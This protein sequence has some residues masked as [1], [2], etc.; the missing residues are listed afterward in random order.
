[1]VFIQK[2]DKKSRLV[3]STGISYYCLKGDT[4]SL[5]ILMN[6]ECVFIH[7][8]GMLMLQQLGIE[9]VKIDLP[10][11]LDHVNC[12]LAEGEKGYIVIDTG[13][14]DK[15]ARAVWKEMLENKFVER[16]VLTHLHPDHSGYAGVLQLQTNASVFMTESDAKALEII[17]TEEALPK[18]AKEYEEAAVPNQLSKSIL[19]LTSNFSPSVTPIPQVNEFLQEGELIPIGNYLYEVIF[20][21]GHSE[22]LVCFYN[23]EKNVL[24]STDHILPKITPNISY[25]FYGE[26]NPLQSYENS[27][28]KI[29]QLDADFVIPSHGNPFYGANE[30]IDEIWNHHVQRFD[31]ILD[32]LQQPAN[33]FEVCEV[34]FQRELSVYDYQFAIGETIAHLEYLREKGECIRELE[35]GKWIYYRK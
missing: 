10:F 2:N 27:L 34:L 11:R 1:M 14:N 29:K 4:F 19:S 20:T 26:K 28:E 3:R 12:F 21:P 24:L 16:I 32:S 7:F 35:N 8:R 23:R 15:K 6:N 31:I 33:I 18:L 25:W 22:G 30:R 5:K 9:K 13:L 17:W